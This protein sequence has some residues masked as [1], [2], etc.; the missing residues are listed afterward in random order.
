MRPDREG[1]G[2][3]R[4]AGPFPYRR[5]GQLPA[6][7]I[8]TPSRV[9]LKRSWSPT[10]GP[11]EVYCHIVYVVQPA[12]SS[13][14]VGGVPGDPQRGGGG[15]AGVV[16]GA[17][18]PPA[19]GGVD[20]GV[21]AGAGAVA[22][23][24]VADPAHHRARRLAVA[25]VAVRV[26]LDVQDTG[27][28]ASVGGPGAPAV[29]EVVRLGGAARGVGGGEVVGAADHADVVGAVVL[30][31]VVRVGVVRALRG[32]G[33]GPAHPAVPQGGPGDVA[34]VAGDVHALRLGGAGGGQTGLAVV[35]EDAHAHV[36]GAARRD[37]GGGAVGD[38][39]GLRQGEQREQDGA[40]GAERAYADEAGSVHRHDASPNG[41]G[42]NPECDPHRM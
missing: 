41:L 4:E 35:G 14:T 15:E 39:G 28:G 11:V 2:S 18:L 37:G 38:G 30:L 12:G 34:L 21:A 17:L 8:R 13:P 31:R 40:G 36:G 22:V 16:A 9:P 33:V 6:A 42:A 10:V 1:P 23:E 29:H 27:Q 24:E 19:G 26:P 7:K 3:V 5:P 20:D 32:L 25:V